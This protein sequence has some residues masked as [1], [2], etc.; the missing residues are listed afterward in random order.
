MIRNPEP[1]CGY[2]EERDDRHYL[3]HHKDMIVQQGIIPKKVCQFCTLHSK[4][5]DGE[6]WR[7][8]GVVEEPTGPKVVEL[9]GPGVLRMGWNIATAIAGFV[10]SGGKTVS[11]EVYKQRLEIC[12]TCPLREG[13][14]CSAKSCGC[15]LEKKAKLASEKCPEGKW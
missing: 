12:D 3:C 1:E 9:K 8:L 7:E 11:E 4:V 10:A 5:V 15:I 13:N 14:R 6:K 2:R